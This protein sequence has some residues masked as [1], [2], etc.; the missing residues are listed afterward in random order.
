MRKPIHICILTSAHSIEDVRVFHKIGNSFIL[1]GYRVSWVGPNYTFFDPKDFK[2][3]YIEYCLFP[4]PKRK[5]GRIFSLLKAYRRG[6]RISDVDVIYSPDPDSA[7]AAIWLAKKNGA[8]VIFDIHEMF[9][10]AMLSHWINGP[11]LNIAT[12]AIRW[13]IT[14]IGAGCDLI[15]G[16]SRSVLQP[17]W[18]VSSKKMVVRNCA[19]TWF[20]D[21]QQPD[22][23]ENGRMKFTFMHG[24]AN[25]SRGTKAVMEALNHASKKVGNLQCVMIDTFSGTSE[26]F[27]KDD[28]IKLMKELH[29]GDAVDLRQ[30]IPM[31]KMP[32]LLQECDVGLVAYGRSLGQESLP[33]KLFEYMAVGLPIIAPSYSPE[34]CRILEQEKCGVVVDFE[35][36]VEISKVMIELCN[37]VKGCREMGRRAR[38]AFKKRHNWEVEV[39]PL[40]D[41]INQWF[42][43]QE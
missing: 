18:F 19:P 36:P 28:F 9:H 38:E 30:R 39:R 6:L 8:K 10:S 5:I 14:K 23:F 24:K 34:I 20:S 13:W 41:H 1:E 11:F 17:Y 31:Q 16:V 43:I 12:N 42:P 35:N 40:L 27:N 37:D 29:L 33:N 26:E 7:F 2:R 22:P 4:G 3:D 32:S 25:L 15:V 21:S